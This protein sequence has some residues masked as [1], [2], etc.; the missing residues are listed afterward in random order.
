M[1]DDPRARRRAGCL[2]ALVIGAIYGGLAST[3]DFKSASGGLQSD[4]AT[5]YLMGHSLA[6]DGD[7]A[8]RR[9][10]LERGFREFA[11]GPSGV[12]LKRGSRVTG[13]TLDARPPFVAVLGRPDSDRTRLFYGKSF[14]YPLFAAPFVKLLGTEGFLLFN[15][16]LLCVAFLSAYLFVS[17]RSGVA[18]GLVVASAFVF[19]SVVP[20]YYVWIQPELFNFTL[21]L[22]AYFLW[23]Y[24]AVAPVPTGRG[25]A[26]L[27]RPW[28]DWAAGAVIGLATF[29]KITNV[30]MLAP[31]VAWL[32]WRR[33]W[34]QAVL[35]TAACALVAAMLFGVNVAVSGEWNYQGSRLVG[36][37]RTCYGSYPF[38]QP[39]V[40]LE[41][42]V[43]RGRDEALGGVMF[44]R[45]V[46]WSN[47][48]MNTLYFFVGRNSG[49]VAYFFSAVFG[50]VA[51]VRMRKAREAWQWFV[52]AGVLLQALVFIVT[53]PYTYF[54]GGGSVGNRYFIGVYGTCLFLMPPLRSWRVGA[55][56]WIVG[57]LFMAKLVMNPFYTSIRPGEHSKSGPFRLLPVE[58][59]NINDLPIMTDASRVRIWYGQTATTPGFQIY[60]LDDNSYL[61][62]TPPADPAGLDRTVAAS[63]W[64][65]GESRAE[66][67]VKVPGET[68]RG[69]PVR[70]LK[71]TLQSGPLSTD[72]GVR[73]GWRTVRISLAPNAT[74]EVSMVLGPGVPS[75]LDRA[76]PAYS[77]V[78]SISS[79]TGFTPRL[80]EAGS[81]DTRFLGVR[82][83]PV[84]T[85]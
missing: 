1:A 11:T 48:R 25:S 36:D 21:G 6:S 23:L 13:V 69:L 57:G 32:V 65:R 27:R 24:K 31:M 85:P 66:I 56:L 30:L 12:F 44:D 5:Y 17:A 53:L 28:T 16:V 70:R 71:L 68:V 61:L 72:V 2:A 78:V 52:L 18:T 4:E 20:V 15:A 43:E 42:C 41:T 45:E 7:L 75:K 58:L 33:Q 40:G 84:I 10:D 55:S 50:M 9:E 79:S 34:R 77:W 26:W 82:V 81:G 3:V 19:A 76:V 22:G 47:L 49:L 14:V 60:Y 59:T 67:I 83:R 46:F 35:S 62:E 38:E 63:F 39:S 51:L 80:F 74:Q 29:S 73:V 37:R 8:Y 54:G 64:T